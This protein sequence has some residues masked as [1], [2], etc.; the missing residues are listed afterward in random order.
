MLFAPLCMFLHQYIIHVG[1]VFFSLVEYVQ[2]AFSGQIVLHNNEETLFHL[3]HV[4]V[5]GQHH[6]C[7]TLLKAAIIDGCLTM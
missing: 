4:I 3:S 5:K 6:F 2:L 1:L 7:I